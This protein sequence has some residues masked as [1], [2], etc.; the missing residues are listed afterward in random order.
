[1]KTKIVIVGLGG[2]GGY[3]GGLLAKCYADNPEI[4][5]YFVARGEHLKIV[6]EK[7]LKLITETDTFQIF[8]FLTT[9][10]VAKI[11]LADYIIMSPKSYDLE[12][13]VEQIKPMI[14][15]DTVILPLLNGIDNSE[16]IRN[17]LPETEVWDGCCYIVAKIKEPGVVENAGNIHRIVFGYKNQS[18]ERLH[19]FEKLLIDAGIEARFYENILTEIWKKF[20]FISTSASLTSYF[21]VSYGEILTDKERLQTLIDISTELIKIANAEGITIDKSEIEKLIHQFEKLPV[22]TTTSMH[23]DFQAEK[24]TETDS[25]TGIVLKLGRKHGIATPTYEKVYT[26]LKGL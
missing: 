1:M 5:I 7:G 11:G 9:N 8:P 23:R 15:S 24:N 4:E 21:D 17:L 22:G 3:F 25:L 13:T 6:Q 26:K 12:S 14:G 19:I 16:R 18:N 20:F 10:D 2:V